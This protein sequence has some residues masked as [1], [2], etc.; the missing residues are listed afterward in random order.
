MYKNL[1]YVGLK[2]I[3]DWFDFGFAQPPK[4]PARYVRDCLSLQKII[5]NVTFSLTLYKIN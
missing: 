4:K 5:F 3:A 2:K 1:M